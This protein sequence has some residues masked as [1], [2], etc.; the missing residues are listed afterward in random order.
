MTVLRRLGTRTG[1]LSPEFLYREQFAY[2]HKEIL[3]RYAGLPDNCVLLGRVQHGWDPFHQ[4]PQPFRHPISRRPRWQWLWSSTSLKLAK[5]RRISRVHAVGSPWLYLL[6]ISPPVSAP[7]TSYVLAMPAHRNELASED[8]HAT[9]AA[10]LVRE[11][12]RSEVRVLLHGLD[13]MT[14]TIRDVYL[15]LGLSVESAGWPVIPHSPRRPSSDI[16]DRINFLPN[17]LTYMQGASELIT[18]AMGTHVLYA[19]SLGLTTVLWPIRH[20]PPAGYG[21]QGI[22]AR[23]LQRALDLEQTWQDEVLSDFYCRPL[24]EALLS[25]L[26]RQYLGADSLMKP[27]ELRGHLRW[28]VMREE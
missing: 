7:S 4:E 11:F 3:C 14:R 16:G 23:I 17:L 2:G 19:G 15:D 22:Q 12:S 18:D 26:A 9:F 10:I 8:G 6:R 27:E 28:T 21:T 13:F 25:E 24:P 20:A 1:A 5:E